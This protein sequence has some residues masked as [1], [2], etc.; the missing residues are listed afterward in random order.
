[1]LGTLIG[2]GN[3]DR[4]SYSHLALTAGVQ[5]DTVSPHDKE[6]LEA[7]ARHW[8]EVRLP[9]LIRG[10]ARSRDL[11]EVHRGVARQSIQAARAARRQGDE[12]TYLENLKIARDALCKARECYRFA[13]QCEGK[14]QA[15]I[16]TGGCS[17]LEN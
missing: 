13:R 10:A 2:F 12:T 16:L 15:V 7:L 11:G 5:P 6:A 8:D 9:N 17:T 4:M 14:A 3:I 1:M